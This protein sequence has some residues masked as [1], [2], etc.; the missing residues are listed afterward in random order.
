MRQ[1]ADRGRH[2]GHEDGVGHEI[3]RIELRLHDERSGARVIGVWCARLAWVVLPVSVGAALSDALDGWST[4]PARVA[5]VLLW[6]AWALGLI[7]LLAPRPWG[8][9]CVRVLA[10]AAVA[11]AAL[12][13]WSAGGAAAGVAIG[14]S[15][16]A[17]AFTLAAPV[18]SAAANSAAYGDE[19]RFPLH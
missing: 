11:V 17:A 19:K 15:L 5:T 3:R 12:A 7:A 14:S 16:I 8:L 6:L 2:S 9:T 18:A 1:A 10:P 13:A 4:A